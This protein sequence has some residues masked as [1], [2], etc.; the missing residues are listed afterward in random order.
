MASNWRLPSGHGLQCHLRMLRKQVACPPAQDSADPPE[1]PEPTISRRSRSLREL[2]LTVGSDLRR[3]G[4]GEAWP[5]SGGADRPTGAG[6]EAAAGDRAIPGPIVP[7]VPVHLL[8]RHRL[9]RRVAAVPA[10][11]GGQPPAG[12]RRVPAVGMVVHRLLPSGRGG[13]RTVTGGSASARGR[14]SLG[15]SAGRPRG[16]IR[17]GS[18][19][20][21]RRRPVR[22]LPL[23]HTAGPA[24]YPGPRP[25]WP[26]LRTT[27]GKSTAT[28][29]E[30]EVATWPGHPTRP[31][32]RLQSGPRTGSRS[33]R[34]H[35]V[36]ATM[37]ARGH[38]LLGWPG[39][40]GPR[41]GSPGGRTVYLRDRIGAR[42]PPA[43]GYRLLAGGRDRR[44]RALGGAS[45][46][47]TSSGAPVATRESGRTLSRPARS[48]LRVNPGESPSAASATLLL[49]LPSPQ[50]EEA[51]RRSYSSHGRETLGRSE[52]LAAEDRRHSL[53]DA[54]GSQRIGIKETYNR[55]SCVSCLL[56][57]TNRGNLP[58]PRSP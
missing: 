39:P 43:R 46:L 27:T 48:V 51:P 56:S 35:G 1:R 5:E 49:E 34:S 52:P 22:H 14:G 29:V 8:L 36:E 50:E 53:N 18:V 2:G 32:R 42:R 13:V 37:S 15:P 21:G 44:Q 41:R 58:P 28:A 57:L 33:R 10:S 20:E 31:R 17:C 38:R 6:V 12:V 26:C 23:D 7:P 47:P 40:A 16:Y 9:R 30:L 11:R 54:N 4:C 45:V 3:V 19:R 55:L 24:S 25:G